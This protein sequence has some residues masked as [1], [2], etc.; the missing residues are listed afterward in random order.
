[1]HHKKP[2]PLEF[3]GTF[4]GKPRR[5]CPLCGTPSYS[6]SG[7]HP[8]CAQENYDREQMARLKA[9][10]K[11]EPP[12]P[13]VD[14]SEVLRPWHKRCP[15]CK[16]QVHVRKPDCQCGYRFPKTARPR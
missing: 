15:K 4:G 11:A 10:K 12:K 16:D 1:M 8:Q 13:P 2:V 7:V 3:R 6:A 5:L 9:Q 14:N